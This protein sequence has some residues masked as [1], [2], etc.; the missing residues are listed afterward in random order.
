MTFLEYSKRTVIQYQNRL[1]LDFEF[2]Y[3][4]ATLLKKLER[5]VK[6]A[7]TEVMHP[8]GKQDLTQPVRRCTQRVDTVLLTH[9]T[10]E[11]A[12]MS[13]RA[14]TI[15]HKI[16]Y[17][18]AVDDEGILKGIVS[19]RKLL[20]SNPQT[21][22]SDIMERH[23]TT[24]NA[25]QTL[26]DALQMLEIHHLLALPAIDTK[27]RLIGTIDVEMY[28]EESFDVADAHHRRDVFQL[29]GFSIEEGRRISTLRHYKIRMPWL[30]CNMIGGFICAFISHIYEDVLARFL[31]LAMFI[32]L[33]LTL[34]ESVSMQSMTQSLQFLRR[35]RITWRL[36]FLRT[37]KEWRIVGAIAVSCGFIV[38]AVSLFWG[39]GFLPSL[40][41]GVGI[42]FSVAVTALFGIVIP[43]FLHL[44][45]LDPKV[46][47]GPVVLM[48]ADVLTTLFYLS[49]AT[50]WLI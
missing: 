9:H 36:S 16:V 30:F 31:L 20:L 2:F 7:M 47:S 39:D 46:A 13:L 4:K 1:S 48:L 21:K 32:P 3:V 41:I 29:I 12:L 18:Y 44:T 45:R 26:K 6:S 28:I 49:L 42:M 40:T 11:E 14:R 17:F 33:V 24:V 38:G 34:S 37:L 27:G 43:I 35:P 23:V 15:E 8:I 50:W 25:D 22:I 5:Y 10:I 19:T